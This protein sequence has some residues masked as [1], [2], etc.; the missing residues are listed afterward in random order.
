MNGDEYDKDRL[1][2]CLAVVASAFITAVILWGL[3][4]AYWGP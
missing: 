1:T 2:G 4:Y 3:W